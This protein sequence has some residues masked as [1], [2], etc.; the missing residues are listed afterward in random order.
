MKKNSEKNK[1]SILESP[2]EQ[3]KP[4]EIKVMAFE[5]VSDPNG[6]QIEFTE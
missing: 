1:M 2:C 4:I 3:K 5:Y 6:R